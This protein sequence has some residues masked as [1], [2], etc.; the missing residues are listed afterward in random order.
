MTDAL[1]LIPEQKTQAQ[2][3]FTTPEAYDEFCRTF[4]EEVRP[5]LERYREARQQSEAD[6]KQRWTR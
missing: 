2:P 5:D 3:F 1:E 6:A 4:V